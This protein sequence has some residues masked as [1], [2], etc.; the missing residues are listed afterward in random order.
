MNGRIRASMRLRCF[1]P[2]TDLHTYRSMA[3]LFGMLF[4]RSFD[5]SQRIYQA[6]VLRGYTGTFWTLSHFRMRPSDWGA[7]VFLSS[8]IAVEVLIQL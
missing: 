3:N 7:L 6:M 8:I 4:V 2:K 5:R 1:H